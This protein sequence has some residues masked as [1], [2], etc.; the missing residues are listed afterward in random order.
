MFI[1]HAVKKCDK[2]AT[3][4][5]LKNKE[6]KTQNL[7]P[8]LKKS[9]KSGWRVEYYV[10]GKRKVI[11]VEKIR[12]WHKN[13]TDAEKMIKETIIKPLTIELLSCSVVTENSKENTGINFTDLFKLYT[14]FLSS[15]FEK[16]KTK[17]YEQYLCY[18]NKLQNYITD[19]KQ[20]QCY[21][22]E[23][24]IKDIQAYISYLQ[25][26][27]LKNA[28][29][30]QH[31]RFIKS[32]FAWCYENEYITKN[33]TNNLKKLK[34]I[35]TEER[36]ILKQEELTKISNHLEKNDFNFYV[37]TQLVYS[38]LLRPIEIYRLQIKNIDFENKLIVLSGEKTK[39]HKYRKIV[40]PNELWNKTSD[41]WE[42]LQK[43]NQD[44][45]IFSDKH[46]PG[47]K[48]IEESNTASIKWR[49]MIKE[50]N[51][52]ESIQLYGLR[53]TA[54]TKLLEILPTNTVRMH[55]NHS[56]ISMT[57]HYGR[58]ITEEMQESMRTKISIY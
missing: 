7:L 32:L 40:I 24:K 19:T 57:A 4:F 43:I 49:K 51:L 53:H 1:F 54:I 17:T 20:S 3:K 36:E 45:Y 10:Q 47:K 29:I 8:E 42:N 21:V 11:R 14:S 12:K 25:K 38:C 13:A 35:E 5:I 34:I 6:M 39:N 48:Q 30:N 9:K 58:H 31:I 2:N 18:I 46:T 27:N 50:L 26:F 44:Y 55:A 56:N 37:F 41:F 28:S 16:T 23:W 22:K 15:K 33:P 52:K